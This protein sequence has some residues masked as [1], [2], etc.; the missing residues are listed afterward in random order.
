MPHNELEED[1]RGEERAEAMGAMS[2]M[3]RSRTTDES[4]IP[5]GEGA[6][7]SGNG[8]R[9]RARSL[10][11]TM[12]EFFGMRGKRETEIARNENRDGSGGNTNISTE[13]L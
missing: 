2:G 4:Q 3:E 1:V 6:D 5:G 12:G 7:M 13:T 10:T 9:S 8:V 11:H